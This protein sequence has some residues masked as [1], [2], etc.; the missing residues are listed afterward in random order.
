MFSRFFAPETLPPRG[1]A[2]EGPCAKLTAPQWYWAED[3][4]G[5]SSCPSLNFWARSLPKSFSGSSKLGR[6]FSAGK[7]VFGDDKGKGCDIFRLLFLRYKAAPCG[8]RHCVHTWGEVVPMEVKKALCIQCCERS[9]FSAA[10]PA[11]VQFKPPNGSGE[12]SD[13]IIVESLSSLAT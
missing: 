10:R 7:F 12:C 6:L 8:F 9:W 3:C 5:A 13:C 11:G 1:A 4:L 2:R